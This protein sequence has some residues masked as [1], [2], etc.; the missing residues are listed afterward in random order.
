[1]V[2][3][4]TRARVEHAFAE[5]KDRVGLFIRTIG[6]GRAEAIITLAN[7]VY[8]MKRWYWLERMAAA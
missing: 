8:N 6:R 4:K 5:P 3:S 2:R 7:M 1:M